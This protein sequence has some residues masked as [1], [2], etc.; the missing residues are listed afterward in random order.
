MSAWLWINILLGAVFF[1]ATAGIPLWM[2]LRWPEAESGH[3]R[4]ARAH[5]PHSSS[6]RPRRWRE[7]QHTH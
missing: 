5:R 6:A 3:A 1:G 2:V 4:P 7:V